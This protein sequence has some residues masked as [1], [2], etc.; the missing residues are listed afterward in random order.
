M[1]LKTLVVASMSVLGLSLISYPVLAATQKTQARH[2]HHHFHKH[3]AVKKVCHQECR[4]VCGMPVQPTPI[5]VAAPRIDCYAPIL[6]AMTQNLGRQTHPCPDWFQRVGVSGGINFDAHWFN[7]NMGY[8]GENNR[9]LSLNDAYINVTALVNDWTKAFASLSFNNTTGFNTSPAEIFN[10]VKEGVYSA[11][12]TNNRL[13]VEQAYITFGNFDCSPFFVQLGKQF[14]DF[15]R[16]QI[17]PIERTMTQVLSES[18]HTSAKIG[19]LTP[20]GFHGSVYAFDNPLIKLGDGHSDT[21]W[22]A[23][24]GYDSPQQAC[25]Q[26]GFDFGVGYMSNFLGV[27]DV[28]YAVDQFNIETRELGVQTNPFGTYNNTVAAWN[29]YGDI[30]SGPF[31]LGARYTTAASHFN[32]NTLSTVFDTT[33]GVGAARPWA[34]DVTASYLFNYWC[35]CNTV[36]IGYQQSGEAVNVLLPRNRWILGATTELWRNASVGLEYGYDRDYNVGSNATGKRTS[37]IGLRGAVKFG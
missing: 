26:F 15:G 33:I 25:Q 1:K 31:N 32:A 3:M 18:L 28:A 4:T 6:D 19:F 2:K 27:N 8:Q 5:C 30:S 22:G 29:V 11:A 13:N 23:S 37:T 16:Y 12:Y 9:R 24:L 36:Y 7:R 17:H 21:I 35:K 14:Q 10:S 20:M 34:Y